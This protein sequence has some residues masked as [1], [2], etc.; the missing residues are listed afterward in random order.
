[1]LAHLPGLPL[2]FARFP[3]NPQPFEKPMPS[4]NPSPLRWMVLAVFALLNMVLQLHWLAL[5]PVTSQAAEFYQVEPL[6]IGFLS[7][8]FMLAYI[9]VGM[10]ASVAIDRLGLRIGVGFGAALIAIFGLMKGLYA[11]HYPMVCAAQIGLA[12]SQPFLLNAYTRLAAVWFPLHERATAAGIASVSQYAGI[13]VAMLATPWLVERQGIDGMLMVYGVA[14]AIIGGVFLLV[15]RDRPQASPELKARMG[16]WEGMLQIWNA[17]GMRKVLYVNF[18]GI[19]VFNSVNTWIEQMLAPRGFTPEDA[20]LTGAAMMAG[21]IVGGFVLPPLSDRI[22]RRVPFLAG[23]TFLA[24]PGLAGMGFATSWPL[25]LASAFV[26]GFAA[27]GAGPI[28]FQ[29]GAELAYPAPES[30]ALGVILLLGQIS[31]A[32]AIWGMA[33]FTGQDGSMGPFMLVFILA[34][35]GN[36]FVCASMKESRLLKESDS[37]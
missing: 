18:I 20:G 4:E 10:P 16:L 12:V 34:F 1:M 33:T 21:G 35:L 9:V 3:P 29:Y 36:G 11:Q 5:A 7:V 37:L 30:V 22:G 6:D 17:P 13:V 27:M 31:G 8:V 19:A 14:S 15:F 23:L 2:G 28:G 32:A 25:L 24:V 26:F